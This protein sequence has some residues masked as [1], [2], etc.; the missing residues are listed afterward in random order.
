MQATSKPV[1]TQN[2]KLRTLVKIALMGA[3]A[4]IVMVFE[5]PLW[6]APPFYKL[7]LSEMVVLM[8]GFVLGPLAGAAIELVKVVINLIITGSPTA[9]VGSL[10]NLLVGWMFVI[11]ASLIYKHKRTMA[12][13]VIGMITGIICMGITGGLVNLYILLPAYALAMGVSIQTFIDAGTAVNAN[14]TDMKS[15]ILL[16]V[17]P[18]N[19]LKGILSSVVVI[20]LY[21]KIAPILLK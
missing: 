18:F 17:I 21:K 1:G 20:P 2:Q 12:G 10:A 13:A 19:A 14:I 8:G 6:F 7:D 3:L 4:A 16:A 5:F 9:G 11:P 15:F